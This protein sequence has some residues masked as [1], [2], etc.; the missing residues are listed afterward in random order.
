MT[1]AIEELKSSSK[2]P[3][4]V[5]FDVIAVEQGIPLSTGT[6]SQ[7]F[8]I[9]YSLYG[10]TELPVIVIIGGITAS[11]EVLALSKLSQEKLD[12]SK[13]MLRK[14][15]SSNDQ[16]ISSGWWSELVGRNKA[17]DTKEYCV[18]SF[19]YI[20]RI[21]VVTPTNQRISHTLTPT[22]Q[23]SVLHLLLDSLQIQKPITIIGSSYGG[24]VGLSFAEQFTKRIKQ[25]TCISASD[26]STHTARAIRSIQKD[27]FE[28]AASPKQKYQALALARKLSI[29]FY[30]TDDIFDAQFI[31]PIVQSPLGQ[32]IDFEK[33]I[34]SYLNHQGQ[35]FANNT[36]IKN[37]AALLDS[38]DSHSVN[39]HKIKC[40]C[41]FLAVP[42][43]RL[44]SY[45]SMRKLAHKVSGKS[46]FYRLESIY[47]HDA[48][49]KEF[50]Q[51]TELLKKIL[52]ES[53]EPSTNYASC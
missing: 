48:F 32:V 42:N 51:L 37:Y 39:A 34:Y 25:L 23:A 44:V 16:S 28:L 1:A 38:I 14:Q 45:E 49:L 36:T 35:K 47:G 21:N 31:D 5:V 15:V 4:S 22:D 7:S 24:M 17:I 41:S 20:S 27:I 52:G 53:D 18:L 43:D 40:S 11:R 2:K 33:T 10:D 6:T 8:E 30:R 3:L 19:N 29:L 50:K 26:R 9:E 12:E 13:T 46:K